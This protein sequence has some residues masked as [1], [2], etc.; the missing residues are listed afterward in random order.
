MPGPYQVAADFPKCK[1]L[2]ILGTSLKVQP[3]ASL[4]R[5]VPPGTP[6]LLINRQRVGEHL[7]LCFHNSDGGD[8]GGGGRV[9]DVQMWQP[10]V[11]TADVFFG[12]DC[13]D[14][15]RELCALMQWPE[16]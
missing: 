12:G 6:R 7:G 16:P 15:V 9:G 3:F 11:P 8:E 10:A 4:V 5:R 2:L 13:D 1:L 14:G